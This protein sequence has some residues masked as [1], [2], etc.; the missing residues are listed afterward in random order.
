M[1]HNNG[2]FTAVT[3]WRCHFGGRLQKLQAGLRSLNGSVAP[4]A[5]LDG[6]ST[7]ESSWSRFGFSQ[8]QEG[9][10]ERHWGRGSDSVPVCTRYAF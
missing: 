1:Q 2:P 10:R 6:F 4:P 8:I 7:L 3:V 9:G 5:P